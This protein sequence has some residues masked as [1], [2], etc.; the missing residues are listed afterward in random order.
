MEGT[1]LLWVY[2]RSLIEPERHMRSGMR[3]LLEGLQAR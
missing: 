2:D 3:I 1:I